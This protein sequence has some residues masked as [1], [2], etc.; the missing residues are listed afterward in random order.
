VTVIT[1]VGKWVI[2]LTHVSVMLLTLAIVWQMLFGSVVPFVGGDVV[3][4]IIAIITQLG[5][6]GLVG[7]IAVAVIFWLFRHQK[8]FD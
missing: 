2:G 1:N 8:D 7:L 5:N 3:G 4:N 6:A